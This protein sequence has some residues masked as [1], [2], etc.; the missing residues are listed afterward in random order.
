MLIAIFSIIMYVELLVAK[1]AICQTRS[2]QQSTV[3]EISQKV[4]PVDQC[5][6]KEVRMREYSGAIYSYIP[7][8]NNRLW[9]CV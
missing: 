4:K 8:E 1:N 9:L 5:I 6:D 7:L 2:T 3:R